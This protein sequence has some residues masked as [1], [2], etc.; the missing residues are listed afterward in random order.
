[1]L[2][3]FRNANGPF[4]EKILAADFKTKCYFYKKYAWT[5]LKWI[6]VLRGCDKSA[7]Y[8][9]ICSAIIFQLYQFP[10]LRERKQEAQLQQ[11]KKHISS[12]S[13]CGLLQK[14]IVFNSNFLRCEIPV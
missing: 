12:V 2:S 6:N 7:L 1:M 5:I 13:V 9:F 4:Y 8:I 14:I 10:K 3:I 11:R